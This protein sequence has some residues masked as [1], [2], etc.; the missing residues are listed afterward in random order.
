[1]EKQVEFMERTGVSF[2][3]TAYRRLSLDGMQTSDP[4]TIPD[5]LSYHTLL[6]RCPIATAA[7]MLNAEAIGVVDFPLDV[8]NA[9]PTELSAEPPPEPAPPT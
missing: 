3:F 1:L 5:R 6:T 7:V 9:S 2:S 4:L 8:N